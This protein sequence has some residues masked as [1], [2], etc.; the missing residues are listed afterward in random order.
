MEKSAI[1]ANVSE[2]HNAFQHNLLNKYLYNFNM[3][4]LYPQPN[5]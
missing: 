2:L 5:L 4:S 3:D 1:N